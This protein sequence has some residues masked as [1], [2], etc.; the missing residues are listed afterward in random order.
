[1]ARPGSGVLSFGA[2]DGES[3]RRGDA[4]E[5]LDPIDLVLSKQELDPAG[6]S[7][8]NPVLARHHRAEVEPD[9]ADFNPVLDERVPRLDKSFRGLQQCFRRDAADVEAGPAEAA[10]TLDAGGPEPELRRPD[11]GHIPAGPGP[12]D[13]DVIAIRHIRST[14]CLWLRDPA[15]N[16]A[17]HCRCYAVCRLEPTQEDNLDGHSG[18]LPA[19]GP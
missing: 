16:D 1:V 10:A 3:A 13:D 15:E 4:P 11:G 17:D 2:G 12:D 19:Y 14:R 8:H 9:I 7:G 6:Q 18:D 5:A